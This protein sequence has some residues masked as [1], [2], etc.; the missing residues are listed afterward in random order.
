MTTQVRA[1]RLTDDLR[2]DVRAAPAAPMQMT[3]ASKRRVSRKSLALAVLVVLLG[4]ILA[5]TAAQM[6]TSRTSVLA[7]A[8]DVEVGSTLTADDFVVASVP[9]DPALAPVAAED[10]S[11]IIGMVAEVPLTKGGLLTRAQ[12][13]DGSGIA[14]GSVL[15]ALPLKDGQFPARGLTPGQQVLVVATP[16]TTGVVGDVSS[17]GLTE[18][19]SATVAEIGASN[20]TTQLTVVDVEVPQA[21]GATLA[22]LA[23]TGNLAV[24][25]LPGDG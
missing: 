3:A 13:G 15:V 18:S 4:G 20:M 24:V 14:P 5:F 21:D 2:D 19:V 12:I 17:G 1:P 22:A 25:V 23:S 16:G 8:R 9:D 7:V 11:N 10:L 6:L